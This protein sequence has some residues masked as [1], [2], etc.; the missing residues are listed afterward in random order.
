[1]IDACLLAAGFSALLGEVNKV[2]W[3]KFAEASQRFCSGVNCEANI[4]ILNNPAVIL[5]VMALR[6]RRECFS[7]SGTA[8]ATIL[9]LGDLS[10][11][12]VSRV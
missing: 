9:W 2:G 12:A 7:Y 6:F 10:K 1:M 11:S 8:G 4:V 5:S 3:A